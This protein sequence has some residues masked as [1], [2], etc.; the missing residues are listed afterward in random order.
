VIVDT[1]LSLS[2]SGLTEPQQNSVFDRRDR[3]ESSNPT[4]LAGDESFLLDCCQ[5]DMLVEV[6][7]VDSTIVARRVIE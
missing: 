6:A 5:S 4:T 1:N 2:E 7:A 3:A